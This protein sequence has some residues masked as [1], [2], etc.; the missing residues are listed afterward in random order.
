MAQDWTDISDDLGGWKDVST[1][2]PKRPKS[3][4]ESLGLD[5]PLEQAASKPV[6][7]T[8]S[9]IF[10]PSVDIAEGATSALGQ[11]AVGGGDLIRRGLG[12]NR[13]VDAPDVKHLTYTPDTGWGKVGHFAGS[14]AQF[15]APGGMVSKA[16]SKA[17]MLVR[18]GAEALS[19]AGMAGLQSGGDLGSMEAAAA[20]GAATPPAVKGVGYLAR[21]YGPTLLKNAREQYA[22]V[23]HASGRG[24][25]IRS[26][27]VTPEMMER[28]MTAWTLGGLKKQT[29][30]GVEQAGEN[31]NR[32]WEALPQENAVSIKPILAELDS[33]IAAR[34]GIDQ[35][36][37]EVIPRSDEGS[38]AIRHLEGIKDTFRRLSTRSSRLQPQYETGLVY[39]PEHPMLNQKLLEA[40]P[41]PAGPVQGPEQI[42][43]T[44]KISELLVGK[45]GEAPTITLRSALPKPEPKP[46][47]KDLGFFE[48]SRGWPEQPPTP[49]TPG[50]L[51]MKG[52]PK[53]RESIA[54]SSEAD[55]P[56]APGR[57]LT[58][59]MAETQ[60]VLDLAET[61]RNV[62]QQGT[63]P[64]DYGRGFRPKFNN[65]ELP[66]EG[67][68]R[69]LGRLGYE[70]KTTKVEPGSITEASERGI[71]RGS[72]PSAPSVRELEIKTTQTPK[73]TYLE[74]G[75][76]PSEREIN[77]HSLRKQ[78]QEYDSI[79]KA[80]GRYEG[81][82]I[83][84]ISKLK[85]YET[86]AD[87]SRAG[88]AEHSPEIAAA[89]K[90]YSFQKNADTLIGNTMLRKEG[91]AKPLS[92]KMARA[93]GA[94]AGFT[95]GGVHGAVAGQ[96]AL[97]AA[98]Q[99]RSSVWWNTFS[100]TQKARILKT[101]MNASPAEVN[102]VLQGLGVAGKVF[103]VN[104]PEGPAPL[105]PN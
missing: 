75:E 1:E 102:E 53:T 84:D 105:P 56:P 44:P 47:L 50:P 36:T 41:I 12:M 63:I 78:R 3:W 57:H 33:Q 4:R 94:A 39:N 98:E 91:Q 40:P 38:A 15:A 73:S 45:P 82:P 2:T 27:D 54:L 66:P 28:G 60:S 87:A 16:V 31:L 30:A 14:A 55:I 92:H 26:Q 17:P 72:E 59:D 32:Q 37:G 61:T 97:G 11:A 20:I 51:E 23:L 83:A 22:R 5:V 93:A 65:P 104:Q 19:G 43:F 74:H 71:N 7:A 100:S 90:E 95:T 58:P 89:N 103:S 24:N 48:E 8:A 46:R 96:A 80:A 34:Q 99:A 6:M 76:L 18:M 62:Q 25:K 67:L 29:E 52:L 13:I 64:E 86:A 70:V 42:G 68:S 69:N 81:R 35:A 85:A 21:E 101:L 10:G 49:P 79:L 77:V 88:I 9:N